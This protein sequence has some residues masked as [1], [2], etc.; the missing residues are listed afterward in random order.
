MDV[1][2]LKVIL[3]SPDLI[4]EFF[5]KYLA[6]YLLTPET[7]RKFKLSPPLLPDKAEGFICL[8]VIPDDSPLISSVKKR[9]VAS[10]FALPFEWRKKKNDSELIPAGMKEI[11]NLV[12]KV[13]GIKGWGLFPDTEAGE[14]D[15]S[16]LQVNAESCWTQMAASLIIVE[17]GGKYNPSVIGTGKWHPESGGIVKVK[18]IKEKIG[19]FLSIL[20]EKSSSKQT[21]EPIMFVPEENLNEA[22][23][24]AKNKK[25][26]IKSYPAREKDWKKALLEHLSE[27]AVPPNKDEDLKKRIKYANSPHMLTME[28]ERK[29][30]YLDCLVDDIAEKV[31][32]NY[33]KKF[34]SKARKQKYQEPIGGN[35]V[36]F[37]SLNYELSILIL[38]ILMPD[39]ALLVFSDESSKHKNQIIEFFKNAD[40]ILSFLQLKKEKEREI[41]KNIYK[42]LQKEGKTSQCFV[43]ITSGKKT[44]SVM[45]AL[46]GQKLG[47]NLI[48][49][50]HKFKERSP[51]FGDEELILLPFSKWLDAMGGSS[52]QTSC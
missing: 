21:T 52:L 51:V 28:K 46:V 40:V 23:Q 10:S 49:L 32:R 12:R 41:L 47:A 35:L 4:V 42:W 36:I 8:F 7:R 20:Q 13:T 16:N 19:G 5:G 2:S 25:L 39:R 3:S 48:Y 44:V 17:Y 22:K 18:G 50:N 29:R 37:V 34:A 6:R 33:L 43:D 15:L 24:V 1:N 30:Y 38:K 27:M 9:I 11:A 31:R 45:F 14:V 26:K